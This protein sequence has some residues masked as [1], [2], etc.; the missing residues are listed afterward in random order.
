M[1]HG[2]CGSC[3][4]THPRGSAELSD[5]D[6][7]AL[8]SLWLDSICALGVDTQGHVIGVQ[9]AFLSERICGIPQIILSP[10]LPL[11][12]L[13][14]QDWMKEIELSDKRV[15]QGEDL[16]EIKG[17][18]KAIL[19]STD[20]DESL[21][22]LAALAET[23]GAIVVGRFFQRREKPDSSTYIGS[24]KAGELALDAQA[25]EA[26]L[27]IVDDEISGAQ[28]KNLED[29]T[30]IRVIDRTMLILDI[31]AQRA[32]S[33]EGRLQVSLAQ[34]RYQG[35][36]PN[37]RKRYVQRNRYQHGLSRA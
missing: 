4:H 36:K 24:G 9:A 31:F 30:G 25:L 13:P 21:D 28:T 22:E 27:L 29:I 12:L 10:I 15:L 19:I 33:A 5:V 8:K 20:S 11:H 14:Q 3:I 1:S 16:P 35:G 2:I 23:A 17:P 34:L 26:D 37:I 32:K 18:E 6:L 7:T